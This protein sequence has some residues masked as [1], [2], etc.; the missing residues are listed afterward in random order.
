MSVLL[1]GAPHQAKNRHMSESPSNQADYEVG[2]DGR[3]DFLIKLGV[4]LP[5]TPDDVKQAYL[6]KVKTAHPDVGGSQAEFMALHQAF[7]RATEYA[8]FLSGRRKWLGIQVERYIEQDA[9]IE[10]I[11]TAGGHV[12]LEHKHWLARE[13]GEDFAQ[14]LDVVSAVHWTGGE[15]GDSQI[16]WMI[17]RQ[18]VFGTLRR[19]DLSQSRLTDEGLLKLSAF[20]QL[21]QL[22]LE[23]TAVTHHGLKVLE[24][25]PA[26]SFLNIRETGVGTVRLYF[27]RRNFP[28]LEIVH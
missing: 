6:A 14:V 9:A 27:Y 7:E 5:C 22:N 4:L 2:P 3:P 26:L 1:D 23:G 10:L 18:N 17:E 24:S 8:E 11:R 15:V 20:A 25:L 16:D 13:I 28:D 21:E 12:T 19:L